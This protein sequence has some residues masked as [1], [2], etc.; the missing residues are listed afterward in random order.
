MFLKGH[1]EI[2]VHFSEKQGYAS[3]API[4][5]LTVKRNV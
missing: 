5:M 4:I 2:D 1:A 3:Y